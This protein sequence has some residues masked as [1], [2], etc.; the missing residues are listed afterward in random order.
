MAPS[1]IDFKGRF[2]DRVLDLIW[3]Q[4]TALGVGGQGTS[5]ARTP[6]DPE[7]LVLI[8]CTVARRDPRLFDAMLDW[9]M[10]NG[11]HLNVQRLQRMLSTLP[12]RGAAVF[13][14]VASTI[15][16]TS[17]AAKWAR[18]ARATSAGVSIEAEPLFLM[19]DGVP[20]PVLREPD[21][22]FLVHGLLRDRYQPRNAATVFRP[23]TSANLLLRL[24]AFLGVNARCEIL[25]FLLLNQRGSPRAMAHAC[26]YYP[27][28]ISKALAEMG[29]SG[30]VV[31][32]VE[33]RHRHYT[34]VPDTWRTLLL[35]KEPAPTWVT[36][37][38]LFC[39]L[40]HVWTFL[41]APEC[42]SQ[43]PLAQASALRRVLQ[44]D[45]VSGLARSGLPLAFGGWQQHTG[46]SL[47]PFFVSE[48]EDRAGS[49]AAGW[50]RAPLARATGP[51][52]GATTA[53]DRHA[54][55][56]EACPTTVTVH[57]ARRYD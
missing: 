48:M 15:S 56:K 9:L 1:L 36:W 28:T 45:A 8:S 33:G 4:W 17:R 18:S 54:A 27:A 26:F 41:E 10:L 13:A 14:A 2:Q 23:E 31:S 39:A 37:P 40:E 35:G 51:R 19:G 29:E 43:T 12:F 38:L 20:L 11:S 42:A 32:R 7:A 47:L 21:P 24:R 53:N 3:R 16:T 34:L 55:S 57:H 50:G 44:Q 6:L 25:A 30:F 46:E 5:W 22:R 52:P 49:C